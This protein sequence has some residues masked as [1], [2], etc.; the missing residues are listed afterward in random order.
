MSDKED[1]FSP[2]DFMRGRRPELYADSVIVEEDAITRNQFEFYLDTL[3]QRKEEFPFEHFC[4]RLA[5]K[6]LCPNL[7]TQTGPVG[8]GDSKVDSETYPVAD[9]IA[10]RWYQGDPERAANERWAFA[11]SAQRTWR[12]KVQKDVRKIV[13]TKR[14]Y[15][16]IY[17][18][19]NQAI[20]D[21]ERATVEDALR[22]EHGIEVRILDRSWIVE[23]VTQNRRWD[24][25]YETLDIERP[26]GHVKAVRGP[27]D[28]ERLRDLEELDRLIEDSARYANSKYQLAEDCLQTAILARGLDRPRTEIDGR[29]DRAERIATD[30]E[31]KRQLFRIIYQRAWTANWWFDDFAELDRLYK[32]AEPLALDSELVW[33]LEKLVNLWQVGTTWRRE[34]PGVDDVE[35]WEAH[36]NRLREALA[37]HATDTE[38]PTSAL[39]A[40]TELI[41]MDF[42]GAAGDVERLPHVLASLKDILKEV[43]GHLDYPV[44]IVIEIVQD[45]GSAL[46]GDETYDEL[47]ETAIE[48]QGRR[49]GKAE[50]GL[51]RLSRG[52]QKLEARKTYDAI[53]QFA[54]AQSLLAQDENK[55]QFIR[56]L[57]GTALGYEAAGLLWAARANLI[58]ALDR[59]LYE[60]IKDGQVTPESLP[61]IRKL[62][63]IELQL[64]RMPC[65]LVWL[66][67]FHLIRNTLEKEEPEWLEKEYQLI[68]AVV[69]ILVLRT[70]YQD[71]PSLGRVAAVLEGFSLPLSRGAA[72]FALGHE[73]DF[74]SENG[75]V[76]DD[77]DHFFSLW[78]RQPAAADLRQ[79]ADWHL[80]KMV[81][82][83]TVVMG[84]EIELAAENSVSSILLGEAIL[85]FLESFMSTA[86]RLKGLSAAR[87]Y[88]KIEVRQS[89]SAKEPF[90]HQIKEDDCGEINIIVTHPKIA[91]TRLVQH[92]GYQDALFDLLA[93]LVAYLHI[94]F[95]LES[96]H[97]LFADDRAPD[98]ALLAARAPLSLSN[99]LGENPRYYL[100][101]WANDCPQESFKLLRTEPWE[102]QDEPPIPRENA[103]EDDSRSL[104][105]E[106]SPEN[107]YGVDGLKHRDL[108]VFS[109]INIPL[110]DK[111]RWRGL[112]FVTFPD[113]PRAPELVLLFTDIEAG[114]KI[115]RGWRK[116]LGEMDKDEW[117]GLTLITGINN[118][119]PADY[120]LEITID[121]DYL[122]RRSKP[123]NPFML[124]N[125]MQDMEPA[126][127][128]N[129]DRFLDAYKQTGRYQLVP[130]FQKDER[131]EPSCVRELFIEKSK[132]RI[133]PAWQIGPNDPANMAIEGIENPYIPPYVV[134]PP[135][136][137]ALKQL[138]E[139]RL[140]EF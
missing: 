113:T 114:L 59:A 2:T 104:A 75:Q 100:I 82:M 9:T 61:L 97:K 72:L 45:L 80:D 83:R 78:L 47:F 37:H 13:E 43:E 96:L 29:F 140:Q 57:V 107:L 20:R 99:L 63:W 130:G 112:G 54:K 14:G 3:T 133:V 23:R 10:E 38:K 34:G 105:K 11:F 67:F 124:V 94:P 116:R 62:V 25:V 118:E 137:K 87:P 128:A 12:P 40:R 22:E 51:M 101:D 30:Q 95:S 102:P 88:M 136:W 48:L 71:W 60:D 129:L 106:P 46:G 85:A 89:K 110:W 35:N 39:W 44:E 26:R 123:N 31:D 5:E 21:K 76:D 91:L 7:L 98:R 6:E 103:Q 139:Q 16:L 56:A 33:D 77:L 74:R 134:K 17:F 131:S 27:L 84:C 15:S 58:V 119:N 50:Q 92:E 125:R 109:P 42:I 28:A 122:C 132:L 52:I 138:A 66:E 64:G 73:D 111:A 93:P 4:R 79:E 41:F 108:Q 53:D 32:V 90:I 135:I 70:R 86:I 8:G 24:V 49:T 117:I 120:R 18:M 121:H 126:D 127:T 69:G 19:S 68:D 81:V 55:A 115:F 1:Q 36:T 65:V